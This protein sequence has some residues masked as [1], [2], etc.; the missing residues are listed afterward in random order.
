MIVQPN[1]L[2]HWKTN[3]LSSAIGRL[4]A[5]TALLSLWAHCQNQRTWQFPNSEL[6][7]AGICR[8]TGNPRVLVDTLLQLN[9]LE[10]V[11]ENTLEVHEWAETNAKLLHNWAAG[12]K[13]GRPP[14]QPKDKPTENPR[15]NPSETQGEPKGEP[16]REDKIREENTPIIPQGGNDRDALSLDSG[17]PVPH[18]K[19]EATAFRKKKK[20]VAADAERIYAA[21]PRK[22]AKDAAVR[23]IAKRL[24]AGCDPEDLL[25]KVTAYATATDR[26]AEHDRQFIPHPAT[27][28]NRGSFDDDPAEWT[29]A[30]AP[31]K[32]GGG[33]ADFAQ[34][35]IDVAPGGAQVAPPPDRL[36][37]AM[38]A[39][40]GDDWEGW[41]PGWYQL[42]P[43]DRTAVLQ[44]LADNPE[45]HS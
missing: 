12:K 42:T 13:G 36:P 19:S 17:L 41:A 32:N 1:F 11:G 7:I 5:I 28:F 44:W 37:L 22:V 20:G 25:S 8:Y 27:W 35:C 10:K 24:A 38:A 18:D 23:A 29:R 3:A 33:A 39:L 16:I 26:W 43:G 14:K 6:M 4:E 15:D 40:F 21:Y 2:D 9:L 31:Q 34:R 30:E 45:S